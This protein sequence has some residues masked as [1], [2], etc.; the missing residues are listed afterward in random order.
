MFSPALAAPSTSFPSPTST[1]DNVQS[2]ARPGSKKGKARLAGAKRFLLAAASL[3][4]ANG[5]RG[6]G[7]ESDSEGSGGLSEGVRLEESDLV[8]KLCSINY[9]MR[10]QN[11]VDHVNFFRRK[12]C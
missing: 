9:G 5:E 2:T 12:R 11:P 6:F 8:I 4:E 1:T 10:E 3:D 7:E